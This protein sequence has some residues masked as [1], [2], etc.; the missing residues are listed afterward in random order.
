MQTAIATRSAVPAVPYTIPMSRDVLARPSVAPSNPS[1]VRRSFARN[2]EIFAEGDDTEYFYK[3]VTGTVRTY[4]LLNDGRRQIDAFH[5]PGD[6]FGLEPE[7]QH[8]NSAEAVGEVTVTA[9]KRSAMA[10]ND[11]AFSNQ[12]LAA[13]TRRLE[14]AQNHMLVLGC[15]NAQEKIASFLL[16][17]AERLSTADRVDLPMMR[18]DIADH[19]GLTIETVSRTLAELVREGVI[20]LAAGHRAVTLNDR[21]AL[22][23]LSA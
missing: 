1:G 16:G 12:L 9:H 10:A 8:R 14:C 5:L 4:K 22:R 3:V 21:A 13:M 19:L 11:A 23:Q 18:S 20:G 2:E 15:K 17:L 6:V 7:E